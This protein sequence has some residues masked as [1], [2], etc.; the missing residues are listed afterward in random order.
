MQTDCVVN[1]G[2]NRVVEV[3]GQSYERLAIKTHVITDEDDICDVAEKYV[4]PFLQDGDVVFI[5]EKAVACTQR[6]AIP[7][8][9][10][11]PRPL[12]RFLC[13]FVY[14]NPHGIG[15]RMPETMEMALRECGTIRI[16]FA[17]AVSAVGKLFHKK[18]W[19]YKIAGYK[20]SSIDGP[21]SYTLPP[22]NHYVVLGPAE[23]DATAR[24]IS[25]RLGGAPV[26][27]TDINDLD[28]NILGASDSSL[29]RK[30][31]VEILRDN[32]LGQSHEQTPIGL[33]R[34]VYLKLQ[35][36]LFSNRNKN[37]FYFW[38]CPKR[39]NNRIS[40]RS[41]PA[42]EKAQEFRCIPDFSDMTGSSGHQIK[43]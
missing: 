10:I 1:E 30:L 16:L 28:G 36:L 12:A 42:A 25:Q 23:P 11:K 4:T 31:F 26:L 27:I 40:N 3:G 20:A 34:K 35:T 37:D 9:Q 6:R 19:F 32:P 13:K 22:Y 7:V 33:I 29:D 5:T 24:K 39:R 17:A 41:R 14:K 43:R 8:D 18:G 38:P 2:K 15:L 21:C